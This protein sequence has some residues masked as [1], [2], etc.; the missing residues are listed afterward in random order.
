MPRIIAMNVY[1]LQQVWLDQTYNNTTTTQN[2]Y[3][4][5]D[6][7]KVNIKATLALS[8]FSPGMSGGVAGLAATSIKSYDYIDANGMQQHT[9]TD[10]FQ[11]HVTVNNC[12]RI[13]FALDVTEAWAGAVGMI[14]WFT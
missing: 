6:L 1:Y 7:P 2:N 5:V 11:S 4:S 8:I 10:S 13:T 14:Y 3:W 9:E 12:V